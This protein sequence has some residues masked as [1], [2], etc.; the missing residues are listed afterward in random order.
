MNH[1]K[2]P[3]LF[4][5]GVMRDLIQP[6]DSFINEAF[7]HFHSFSESRFVEREIEETEDHYFL[8]FYLPGCCSD[9]IQLEV[10]DNFLKLSV[11]HSSI[12][13]EKNDLTMDQK[14][15]QSFQRMQR[16]IPFSFPI[17]ENEINAIFENKVLRITVPKKSTSEKVIEINKTDE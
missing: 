1:K 6:M 12:I 11:N 7:K 16:L 15:E 14:R 8:E 3:S 17:S 9:Q 4:T 2:L 10:I 5:E 13:E